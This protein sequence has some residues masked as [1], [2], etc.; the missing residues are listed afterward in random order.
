MFWRAVSASVFFLISPVSGFSSNK[1][2]VVAALQGRRGFVSSSK[3]N[4]RTQVN[5]EPKDP[6]KV[7]YAEIASGIQNILVNSPLKDGKKA[8]VK[9]LAG[10]YDDVA[11]RARL[12]GL[13]ESSQNGV[14]MLSFTTCP[15]CLKAKNILQSKNAKYEVLELDIDEDG[16]VSGKQLQYCSK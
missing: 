12:D 6:T 4:T 14:L 13:I 8:L 7:W 15:F 11:V 3:M 1:L 2:V 16:K 10:E 5:A 9:S